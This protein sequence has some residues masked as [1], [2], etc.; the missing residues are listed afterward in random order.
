MYLTL[1]KIIFSSKEIDH[2][3]K[4]KQLRSDLKKIIQPKNID[5]NLD[6]SPIDSP[7]EFEQEIDEYIHIWFPKSKKNMN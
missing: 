1:R 7:V 3:S 6:L 4:I 5:D 2:A